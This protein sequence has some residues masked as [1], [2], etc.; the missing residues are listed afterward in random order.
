MTDHIILV[1][2]ADWCG[3]CRRSKHFLEENHIPYSWFNT[4]LDEEAE[5][6]VREKN[7]GK[8]VIPTIVFE[9]G[10]MLVEPTNEELAD[11]LGLHVKM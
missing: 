9:D 5:K 6:F 11:K 8:R 3:D 4:D 1:F 7:N 10:S 2:G